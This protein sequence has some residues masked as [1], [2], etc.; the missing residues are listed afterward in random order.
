M[1]IKIGD[2]QPITTIYDIDEDMDEKDV[3]KSFKAMKMIKSAIIVKKE[4]ASEKKKE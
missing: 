2:A 3:K 4:K 1:F